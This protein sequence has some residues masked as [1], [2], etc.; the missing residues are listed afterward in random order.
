ML[1]AAKLTP[2]LMLGIAFGL[3]AAGTA[4]AGSCAR[5]QALV[6]ACFTVHGR[7]SHWNGA[8]SARIWPIGSKRMLGVHNDVLPPHIDARLQSFDTELY[9]NFEVCPY[10]PEVPGKMQFVCVESVKN[11]IYK[12]RHE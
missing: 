11:P 8:P 6:G 7:L 5:D 10:T 9:G 2:Y 12:T 1:F 4:Q 3:S